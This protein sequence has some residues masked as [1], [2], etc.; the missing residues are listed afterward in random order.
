[1]RRALQARVA[2]NAL[3]LAR[4]GV[5]QKPFYLAGQVGGQGFSVHA[6][7]ERLILTR[8]TSGR[9]EIELAGPAPATPTSEPTE[10]APPKPVC[11]DGSPPSDLVS[12]SEPEPPGPG[13][14]PLDEGL[15]R[16]EETFGTE[17]GQ[18]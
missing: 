16:L 3:E 5:P 1:V 18:P 2:Q 7:G 10:T 17:G 8:P 4:T 9:E 15:R 6:E 11:P 14:S 13:A 12:P